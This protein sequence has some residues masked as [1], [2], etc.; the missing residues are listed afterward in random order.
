MENH[1][2]AELQVIAPALQSIADDSS[3]MN[4]AR[5]RAKRLLKNAGG[6]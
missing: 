3:V 5:Q 6:K 2:L 1:N 4:I